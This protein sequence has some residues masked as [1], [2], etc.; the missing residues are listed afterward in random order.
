MTTAGSPAEARGGSAESPRRRITVPAIRALTA[1]GQRIA[2]ITAYDATFAQML[3]EAG[4]DILLVGDSLGMVVQGLDSTLPVTVD[5]M[6]YHCRSVGRGAR[7][8]LVVGDLPFMSWQPSLEVALRNAGRFLS[9][10][11]AHAVKLEGGIEAADTIRKLVSL[12]I[13]VMG[14]V[15]LLPQSVHAMGGF[16]VQGKTVEDAQRV[17][18]DAR[19][20]AEAGAFAL[21]LEG[22]PSDLAARI[23]AE[24]DIPTIGIGAGLSCDG[25]VLVCY[26]LLGL[27]PNMRPKFVKR[28]AELYADGKAAARAFC[29]E[30]RAGTFPSE[31]HAF[32]NVQRPA[33]PARVGAV[34]VPSG[35]GPTH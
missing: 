18:D 21:V 10:G 5:E 32:G 9:E 27:T 15:G 3:D 34:N 7:S 13:P 16:R 12:G 1:R 6:V 2:M 22:I 17:L 30:V 29:E 31:E 25:Q 11:G 28:Y 8:A 20:V 24:L 23:T 14:H 19:A 4:A 33:E 35:Y 26:D